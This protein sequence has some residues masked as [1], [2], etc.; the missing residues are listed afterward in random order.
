MYVFTMCCMVGVILDSEYLGSPGALL[1]SCQLQVS[2]L[3]IP[4]TMLTYDMGHEMTWQ[5]RWRQ[6]QRGSMS[7]HLNEDGDPVTHFEVSGKSL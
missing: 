3:M 1:G 6:T 7:G 5:A 4:Q 2:L